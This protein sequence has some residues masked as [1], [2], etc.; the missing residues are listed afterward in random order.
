MFNFWRATILFFLQLLA[1]FHIPSSDAQTFQFLQNLDTVVIYWD[2]SY[3][4]FWF[5]NCHINGYEVTAHC[6][7][8]CL[9]VMMNDVERLLCVFWPFVYVLWK[10]LSYFSLRLLL[11]LSCTNSLYLLDINLLSINDLQIFSLI[12]WVVISLRS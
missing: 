4:L 8:I 12:S 7:M 11:L 2:F 10:Y 3:T 6:S 1:I 5:Y 9:S